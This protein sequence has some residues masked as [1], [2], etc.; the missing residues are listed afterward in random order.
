VP[1]LR[2]ELDLLPGPVLRDGQPSHML[3]DPARNRYFQ[4]DWQTFEILRCWHLGDPERI[5]QAVCEG[6]TLHVDVEDV[7][8]VYA[9]L[10]GNQLLIVPPGNTRAYAQQLAALEGSLWRKML[11]GYLFFRIPLVRPD[12]WLDAWAPRLGWLYSRA[13]R[14][15]TLCALIFGVFEV[16]RQWDTFTTTLV[17]T[18]SWSGIASYGVALIVVKIL[19]EFGHA[20]TAKR[21]GCRIPSMGAAFLVLWPVAYTDTT[22]VW[23]LTTRRERLMVNAAGISTE[24]LIGIWATAAWVWLPDGAPKAI[25]FVLATTTWVTSVVL[26][27]SPFMR[28]D[29]YYLLSDWLELPNLHDRAFAL[30]R[31]DLRERLFALG[32]APPEV[33]PAHLRRGLIAFAWLTW[34][35]RLSV[36]VGIAALVYAFF[37]KAVGI[38]LFL[39]EIVFFVLQPPLR[40]L[41]L[42]RRRWPELRASKRARVSA[43][44]VLVLLLVCAV[45]WPQRVRASALVR[46]QNLFVVYAP[47]HAQLVSLPVASGGFVKA[48][49]VL[50]TMNAPDL[51]SAR[52][53]ALA[54]RDALAWQ[55]GAGVFDA[56]Q[57][58]HLQ[59]AEQ[60]LGAADAQL[61][62]IGADAA[63]YAPVAPFDGVLLKDDPDLQPGDWLTDREPLATLVSEHGW[64]VVTWLDD[65]TVGTVH[66]GA[67]A[68]FFTD[69]LSGPTLRL[70]VIDV[71]QDASNTLQDGELASVAGGHIPVRNEKG[72]LYPERPIYRVTLQV[73]NDVGSL[74]GHVWRGE[75]VIDGGYSVPAWYLLSSALNV[76]WREAGF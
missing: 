9:F 25:A 65:R 19:H 46:P 69:G 2:E 68:R 47:A 53:A 26:N 32:D 15:A 18:F 71:E 60:A 67:N 61:Q 38:L 58:A 11:H 27:A 4:L 33:F 36:F 43:A 1:P 56:T 35:Y 49:T 13:F 40:E 39:V 73:Q 28:F 45:P 31:W 16:Y 42:W 34:L 22:E 51:D 8:R 74:R 59:D 62:H 48:G 14:I 75:V 6:T 50:M 70:R 3:H 23:R 5:A 7:T 21:L 64:Q 37:I 44:C 24:I 63:H 30:A 72:V 54:R 29:G 66:P 76:F 10:V 41:K 17:D 20:V 12:R 57:R 55:T 52:D